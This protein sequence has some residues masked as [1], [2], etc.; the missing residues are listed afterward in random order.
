MLFCDWLMVIWSESGK[1][2]ALEQSQNE[3]ETW[4]DY[5]KR[6]VT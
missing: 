2:S 6:N 1:T 5:E 3:S 4:I